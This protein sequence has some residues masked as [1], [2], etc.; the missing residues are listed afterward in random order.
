MKKIII[1]GLSLLL[2]LGACSKDSDK[3][4]TPEVKKLNLSSETT[5]IKIGDTPFKLKAFTSPADL[6]KLGVWTCSDNTVAS[7]N[8]NGEI[9]A[10]GAGNAKIRFTI[11]NQLSKICELKVL[12]NIIEAKGITLSARNTVIEKGDN[13][14]LIAS[15]NSKDVNSKALFWTSS[16][17]DIATVNQFG[18]ITAI[19]SGTTTIT[20]ETSNRYTAKCKVIVPEEGFSVPTKMVGKWTGI[21]MELISKKYGTVYDET[22]I[23]ERLLGGGDNEAWLEK[24]R[25]A[26]PYS[27]T[28]DNVITMFILLKS[29]RYLELK[30]KLTET[31]TKNVFT[32]IFDTLGTGIDW[33]SEYEIQAMEFDGEFVSIVIDFNKY[34]N[35]KVYFKVTD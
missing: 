22:L 27:I 15:F 34:Y 9:T 23:S 32:G 24:V 2:L 30:G 11:S 17:D 14:S 28:K 26:Y 3:E 35:K 33:T 25:T 10:I 20:V 8:Q 5:T 19:N 18:E 29:G 6:E 21:K 1:C 16:N 13:K 12:D 4:K 7:I 31:A